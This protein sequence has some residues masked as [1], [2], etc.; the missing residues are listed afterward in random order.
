MMKVG[1][2]VEGKV[3]RRRGMRDGKQVEDAEK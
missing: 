3:D 1:V 2:I